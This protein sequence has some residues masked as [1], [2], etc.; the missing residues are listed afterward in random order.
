MSDQ[1]ANPLIQKALERR[2]ELEEEL[3]KLDTFLE[4]YQRLEKTRV[5]LSGS[6]MLTLS[7]AV[8]TDVTVGQSEQDPIVRAETE[9]QR[10]RPRT[11]SGI[12]QPDYVILVRDILRESGRPLQPPE[13]LDEIHKKG[14]HVGGTKEWDNHKTKLWRAKN[15]HDVILIPGAGYW[16]PEVACPSVQYNPS[17]QQDDTPLPL[18]TTNNQN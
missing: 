9:N 2:R 12:S 6:G 1:A 14:R 8:V 10:T 15:N 7:G 17:Q 18:K 13:I 4:V 5:Q 16:L 11:A 3:R